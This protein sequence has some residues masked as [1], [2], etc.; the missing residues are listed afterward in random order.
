M[1]TF[2]ARIETWL[3]EGNGLNFAARR[4]AERRKAQ[5]PPD[6]VRA[7]LK[8]YRCGFCGGVWYRL[9]AARVVCRCGKSITFAEYHDIREGV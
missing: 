1:T 3:A 9:L 6:E 2:K 7:E 4:L 8:G 5:P